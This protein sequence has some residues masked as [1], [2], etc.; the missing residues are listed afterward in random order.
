MRCEGPG[1][2]IPRLSMKPLQPRI[3]ALE[4]V[5]FA[6]VVAQRLEN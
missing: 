6:S 1:I 3:P 4:S 2:K 5:Q